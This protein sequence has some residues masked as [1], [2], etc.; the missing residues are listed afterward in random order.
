MTNQY[1]QANI[2]TMELLYGRGYL[3]MGGDSEVARIVAPIN[4]RG[5]RLL[6]V[7]CG[8]GGAVITLARDHGAEQVVGIDIDSGLLGRAA[9]LIEAAGLSDRIELIQVAPGPLIFA[10]A[11]FDII[12]LTAVSCHIED[13]VPF[14][15][16]IRRVIRPGGYVVGG[17]WFLRED[18]EAYRRWEAMLRE[19][20]LHFYFVTR[21]RFIDALGAAGFV[22]PAFDD[23][24]ART[25]EL[26]A[27][28]LERSRGELRDTLI[29]RM[30]QE[31][32]AA[33]LE[34]TGVRA[35]G[36]THGGSGYGHFFAARPLD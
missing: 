26:A 35:E 17:E 9:E 30:G 24:S 4:V 36:L 18:N 23:Q 2:E 11:S 27:G 32:Y 25:A 3:S 13:L 8:M 34:W 21:A 6:D 16:E 7:G 28:Y 10:N 20:G 1:D 19:R 22:N 31:G 12:Y 5:S 29:E 14:L 33:H 15:R